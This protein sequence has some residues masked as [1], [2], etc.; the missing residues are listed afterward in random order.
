MRIFLDANVIFAAAKADSQVAKLLTLIIKKANPVTS[1]YALEEARR[2]IVAKR[3]D[4]IAHFNLLLDEIEIVGT[5][6]FELSVE[7][8]EKDTPILC[9]AIND[10]CDY[11]VTGDKRDFGH[12]YGQTIKGVTVVNL[13]TIADILLGS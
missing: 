1:D 4:W 9:A 13:A 2:N 7:L 6:S 3:S 11:L 8:I 5:A 10:R 12:L